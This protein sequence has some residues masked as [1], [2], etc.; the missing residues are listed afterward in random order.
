MT[1]VHIS[2]CVYSTYTDSIYTSI[3]YNML[4]VPKWGSYRNSVYIPFLLT[5]R[6]RVG[7]ANCGLT[8][9]NMLKL[10]EELSWVRDLP[11]S[12]LSDPSSLWTKVQKIREEWKD[13]RSIKD[14]ITFWRQRWSSLK[15]DFVE[16]M[17][18]Q[19]VGSSGRC[20]GPSRYKEPRSHS[21]KCDLN[22]VSLHH[23]AGVS[24]LWKCDDMF[25]S[26]KRWIW[27]L[28]HSEKRTC[29][30]KSFLCD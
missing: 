4:L 10:F 20:W 16:G 13:L 8:S 6:C 15:S 14:D 7:V 23:L 26:L 17:G 21:S 18:C 5:A 2:M 9:L 25:C 19:K 27:E 11:N 30:C 28:K 12:F 3:I 1:C 24:S 22:I 29:K